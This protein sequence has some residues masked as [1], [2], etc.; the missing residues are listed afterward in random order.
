VREVQQNIS[1]AAAAG[2]RTDIN[3]W[4]GLGTDLQK[5]LRI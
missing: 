4:S 2:I 1:S 3:V 5:S